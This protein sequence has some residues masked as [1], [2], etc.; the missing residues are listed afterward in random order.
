MDMN[1]FPVSAMFDASQMPLQT[2]FEPNFYW[3][4]TNA[5]ADLF[6]TAGF[7]VQDG[8]FLPGNIQ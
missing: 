6:A 5:Y 2:S 4:D 1:N 8:V 7:N 3:A